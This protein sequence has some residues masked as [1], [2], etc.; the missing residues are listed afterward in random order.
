MG[1]FWRQTGETHCRGFRFLPED[2]PAEYQPPSMWR[3]YLF[4]NA[5]PGYVFDDTIIRDDI[6]HRPKLL[7]GKSWPAE[8]NL[9][10]YVEEVTRPRQYG[11]YSFNPDDFQG[12]HNCVTWTVET[13]NSVAGN[14]LP[15]VRQGRIRLMEE[16]LRAMQ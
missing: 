15:S 7:A 9:A 16:Q 10:E 14:V 1:M 5:V 4:E 11:L 8:D 2:L 3:E 12:C 6:E 13:V